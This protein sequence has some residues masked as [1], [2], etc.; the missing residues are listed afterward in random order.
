MR[1][2]ASKIRRKIVIGREYATVRGVLFFAQRRVRKPKARQRL[3]R[4]VSRFLPA[5]KSA[6]VMTPEATALSSQGFAMI[7]GVVTAQM[8]AEA[9]D[10][11]TKQLVYPPYLLNAPL[12]SIEDTILPDSHTLVIPEE[13]VV[14]C[15]HLLDI[16]NHPKI[17]A[18]VEGVFGCRPTVGYI[19]A[20]WSVPTA[21]GKPRHAELFHRDFDDVNFIK[22]FIYLT[23][24][25]PDNGPHEYIKGSHAITQLHEIKRYTDEEVLE[26]FGRERLKSFA[27]P[28]GTAFLENT[29]GLHRGLAVQADRRLILQIVYSMLPMAYGPAKP[30]RS[31][32]FAPAHTAIDPYVNRVYVGRA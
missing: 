25:K 19:S 22:L 24:V 15:P 4:L 20:W 10:H 16:A 21:D 5:P 8:I 30:Y 18:A 14:A 23:D 31:E 12:V 2:L 3:S 11:L 26:A 28:P 32:L 17:L 7:E 6:S 27:G 13:R 9:R 1:A 29:Y